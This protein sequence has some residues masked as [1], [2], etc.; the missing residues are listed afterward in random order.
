MTKYKSIKSNFNMTPQEKLA[1]Y[2][3]SGALATQAMTQIV[4]TLA[5]KG[6]FEYNSLEDLS[7]DMAKGISVLRTEIAKE[8]PTSTLIK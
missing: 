8:M 2:N 7:K 3:Q 1:V 5:E 4:L 6:S